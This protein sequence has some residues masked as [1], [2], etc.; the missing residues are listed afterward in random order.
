MNFD[1]LRSPTA[2]L[3]TALGSVPHQDALRGFESW[4]EHEGKAISAA[5]DRARTPWLRM[6]DERG[7]AAR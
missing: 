3:E 2:F 4:W 6:F 7:L 1:R 5:V